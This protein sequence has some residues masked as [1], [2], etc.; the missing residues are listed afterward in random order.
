M[1][2]R[3]WEIRVFG[4]FYMHMGAGKTWYGVPRDADVAFEDVVRVHGPML[5]RVH[6]RLDEKGEI[7]LHLNGLSENGTMVLRAYEDPPKPA[8]LKGIYFFPLGPD[9]LEISYEIARA[10]GEHVFGFTAWI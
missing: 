1:T 6:D 10:L 3:S 4:K 8:S 5:F 7:L 2:T 9:I